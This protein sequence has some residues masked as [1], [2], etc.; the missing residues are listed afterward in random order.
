MRAVPET[1]MMGLMICCLRGAFTGLYVVRTGWRED[2]LLPLYLS[3]GKIERRSSSPSGKCSYERPTR[4]TVCG[5]TSSMCDA[6][7][8]CSAKITNLSLA[9]MCW[10]PRPRIAED[11]RLMVGGRDRIE[12]DRKMRLT[13]GTVTIAMRR[14]AYPSGCA[15]CGAGAG[16]SEKK[17]KSLRGSTCW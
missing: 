7:A 3:R 15:R 17:K 14:T 11:C 12:S 4:G 1:L 2:I 16:C 6:D 8:G 9:E 10:C 13:R 5:A